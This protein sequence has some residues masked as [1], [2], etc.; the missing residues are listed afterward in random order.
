MAGY[1]DDAGFQAWLTGSGYTIPT[2]PGSLAPAVLRQRGSDYLDAVY[3]L[4]FIGT[5]TGGID[6]ERHFPVTGGVTRNGVALPDNVVPIHIINASYMA[7]VQEGAVPGSLSVI[8][9]AQGAVT[10]KKV[11]DLEIQYA[12]SAAKGNVET[13]SPVLSTV[14]GMVGPYLIPDPDDYMPILLRSVGP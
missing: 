6:Q 3:G 8:A 5:P 4:R 11:G 2:G 7:A 9:T 10:R 12:G 13:L 1:G 14:D